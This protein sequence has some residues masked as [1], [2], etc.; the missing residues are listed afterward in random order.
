MFSEVF[1]LFPLYLYLNPS[2]CPLSPAYPS[3][4]TPFRA[5]SPQPGPGRREPVADGQQGPWAASLP[6]QGFPRAPHPPPR[7]SAP[8]SLPQ[9]RPSDCWPCVQGDLRALSCFPSRLRP[10]P[11]SLLRDANTARAAAGGTGSLLLLAQVSRLWE[12][13]LLIVW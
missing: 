2:P 10:A 12:N 3:T 9:L 1:W 8:A 5:V 11:A 4:V 7:R 6:L 13:V